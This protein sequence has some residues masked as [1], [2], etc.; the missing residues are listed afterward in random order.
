MT[1][2]QIT[3]QLERYVNDYKCV[4]CQMTTQTDVLKI[5]KGIDE[6]YVEKDS[7]K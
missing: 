2:T 1:D 6:R 4:C 5:H 7:R 3:L